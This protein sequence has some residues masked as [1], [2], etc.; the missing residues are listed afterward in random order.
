MLWLTT[1]FEGNGYDLII[2]H[3]IKNIFEDTKIC[4]P[5]I[6]LSVNILIIHIF[7]FIINTLYCSLRLHLKNHLGIK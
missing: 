3:L 6:C 4:Q 5:D 7:I 1:F 2:E